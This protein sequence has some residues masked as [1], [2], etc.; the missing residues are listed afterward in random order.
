MHFA[1][2]MRELIHQFSTHL[3]DKGGQ[4][5]AAAA[6]GRERTDGTWVGWLEFSPADHDGRVLTTDNETSQPNRTTLEYWASGLGPIYLD[7]ALARAQG[8]LP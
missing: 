6:Y 5:Y 4:G 8:E 2:D 7:G 3:I 1:R